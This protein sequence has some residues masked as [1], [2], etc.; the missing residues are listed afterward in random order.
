MY[1]NINSLTSMYL[2]MTNSHLFEVIG[3]N[4][5]IIQLRYFQS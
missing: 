3:V 2:D 4:K 5:D 1:V